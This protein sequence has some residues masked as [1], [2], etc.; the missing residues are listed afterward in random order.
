MLRKSIFFWASFA[1]MAFSNAQTFVQVYQDRANQISQSNI[2]TYLQEFE[3]IGVKKQEPH[4]IQ[5]L[6]TG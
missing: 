3:A 5:T 4:R 2:N 1:T 6:S